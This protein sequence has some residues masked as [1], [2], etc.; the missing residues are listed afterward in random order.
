MGIFSVLF[1]DIKQMT[2]DEDINA[3]YCILKLWLMV[4]FLTCAKTWLQKEWG[5]YSISQNILMK[6]EYR[7]DIE[8]GIESDPIKMNFQ[9][10]DRGT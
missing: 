5:L 6:W 10:I 7:S 4:T 8:V 1:E 9:I 3:I 2:R